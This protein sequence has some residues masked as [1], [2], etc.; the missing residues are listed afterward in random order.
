MESAG[1]GATRGQIG[2]DTYERVR[3]LIDQ[4]MKRSDAFQKVAED[5]QRT[6]ATVQTAF[7]RVARSMPDG[8]GVTQRP[9]K[10]KDDAASAPKRARRA[11]TTVTA[12]PSIEALVRDVQRALDALLDEV[13]RRDA[14][15]SSL[16]DEAAQLRKIRQL[17]GG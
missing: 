8:G 4:G 13:R 9:R 10:A 15:T 6:P 1:A 7:Y 3:A 12:E 14:A 11:A 2:R 5:T 16:R 17:M